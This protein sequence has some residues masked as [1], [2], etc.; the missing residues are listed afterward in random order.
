MELKSNIHFLVA[1][2]NR[3]RLFVFPT[4]LPW[5]PVLFSGSHTTQRCGTQTR[6]PVISCR[7]QSGALHPP[8]LRSGHVPLRGSVIELYKPNDRRNPPD[9]SAPSQSALFKIIHLL[10]KKKHRGLCVHWW[11][12]RRTS[13]LKCN[14][15]YKKNKWQALYKYRKRKVHCKKTW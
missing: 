6:R 2:F 5:L 9:N 12:P 8:Q 13:L 7:S 15:I 10:K 4:W 3:L 11:Q 1:V 14:K